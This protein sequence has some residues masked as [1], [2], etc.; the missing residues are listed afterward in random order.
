MFGGRIYN[1]DSLVG[2]I[3]MLA[4]PVCWDDENCLKY[5][6]YDFLNNDTVN[7]LLRVTFRLLFLPLLAALLKPFFPCYFQTVSLCLI[8]VLFS[9]SRTLA[10]APLILFI[11]SVCTRQSTWPYAFTASFLHLNCLHSYSVRY[12]AHVKSS[13]INQWNIFRSLHFQ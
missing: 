4:F 13:H 10:R 11:I 7:G 6:A 3:P 1:L 2:V 9:V 12:A 8:N 5:S